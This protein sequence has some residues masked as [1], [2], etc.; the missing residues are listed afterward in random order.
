MVRRWE[1]RRIV[2]ERASEREARHPRPLSSS[3]S[4]SLSSV[5][6]VI[7]TPSPTA[8]PFV[9]PSSLLGRRLCKPLMKL[10]FFRDDDDEARALD[11][12]AARWWACSPLR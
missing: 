9:L 3:P 7:S 1:R 10:K 5:S 6:A 8:A 12:H 4:R 11:G 2:R